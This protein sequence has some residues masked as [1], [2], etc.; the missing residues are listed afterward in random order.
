ME[1][2][3]GI[4]QIKN[5]TNNKVYVGSSTNID[6][7]W[8]A[9]KLLL[10]KLKHHSPKLQNSVN[11]H[12]IENFIFEVIEE[13]SK[14]LLIEREQYWIDKLNSY[15]IGF[16]VSPNAKN[17]LGRVMSEETKEKIRKKAIGNKRR[18][19]VKHSDKTK[20]K[21]SEKGKN[22]IITEDV[23]NRISLTLKGR[24]ISEETREKIRRAVKGNQNWLGRKHSEETKIKM[25][26]KRTKE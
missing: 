9:H 21:I 3:T 2:K 12:G 19:G 18:L 16:N 4:Y 11:K 23:K 24:I 26:K 17:S 10:R 20:L 1:K 14:E 22:K 15:H 7:R 6:A 8:K 13:C 5:T 25:R